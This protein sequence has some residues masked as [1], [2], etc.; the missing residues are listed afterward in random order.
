VPDREQIRRIVIRIVTSLLNLII[1]PA[2]AW[3]ALGIKGIV[4]YIFVHTITRSIVAEASS[5]NEVISKKGYRAS[6]LLLFF[7]GAMPFIWE[8]WESYVIVVPL[9]LGSFEGAYWSAFHGLRKSSSTEAER[10]SVKTF[11]VFEIS[12]TILAALLVIWLKSEDL[13]QY[14][15]SL[16]SALALLAMA[17]PMSEGAS[18]ASVG[19][20][21]SD[22]STDKAIFGRLT[23]G[24]LGTISYLT[25][26]SMRVV[27][28]QAGGIALLGGMVALSSLV[29]FIISEI[30]ERFSSP[31]D[32]DRRN[33]KVGN[34]L[35][36]TGI[37]VMTISLV[38]TQEGMFL[39]AYL[40]CSGGT[41]GI[42]H[43]LEVRIAGQL[44]SGGGGIIGLRER[45]K[46][47]TQAKILLGYL[48]FAVAIIAYL[49][50]IPDV[51]ILLIPV[52]LFSAMCCVLNLHIMNKMKSRQMA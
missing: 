43:H 15:G 5:T 28:M 12:S 13:A 25:T 26:W 2:G 8:G 1:G 7:G 20:S 14:G 29:G 42:L 36:L 9:L 18:G 23:T 4:G 3:T 52:L 40:V 11:Q 10:K 21:T 45:I 6:P 17:F 16:G 41:S 46:F 51:E 30:N 32:A 27:S 49:G 31:E 47:R 37:V 48:A 33:W 38:Y 22:I 19:F 34:Y 39:L 24:S 44:L 35:S 50:D